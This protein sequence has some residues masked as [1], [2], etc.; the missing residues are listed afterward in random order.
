MRLHK[1]LFLLACLI[2]SVFMISSCERDDICAEDTST[3][4][5]LI[6]KFLDDQTV[7]DIKRPVDLRVRSTDTSLAFLDGVSQDSI[8]IPLKTD[9]LITEFEFTINANNED[10]TLVNNDILSFQYTT[11]EDFVSSACGFKVIYEGLSRTLVPES[12]N[13]NWI[14]RITIEQEDVINETAAHVFI[15]H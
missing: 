11:V 1:I 5:L 6:I 3:T 15:F 9:A 8:M 10:Q 12:D 2:I 4:P 13:G 7:S 14:K